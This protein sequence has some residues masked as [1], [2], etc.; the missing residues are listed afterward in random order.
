MKKSICPLITR[1]AAVGIVVGL[2][3]DMVHASTRADRTDKAAREKVEYLVVPQ[4][5]AAR[6]ASIKWGEITVINAADEKHVYKDKTKDAKLFLNTS[7]AWD[8]SQDK[9][10]HGKLEDDGTVTGG[11]TIKALEEFIDQV[12][13]VVLTQGV[14]GVLQ[15]PQAVIDW[16]RAQG[17]ECYVGRTPAMAKLFNELVGQGKKVGGLFHST[18]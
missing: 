2:T 11:V 4:V 9:T 16:V 18:C 14:D 1:V 12:D 5:L 10:R 17:K 3:V 7:C 15:V 13:V 6:I 8:W